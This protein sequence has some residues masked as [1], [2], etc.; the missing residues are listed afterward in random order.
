MLDLEIV[1]ERSLGCDAWEFVLGMHFSQAVSIIQ[2]QV[3]TIRGVQVLYSD[4]R[5]DTGIEIWIV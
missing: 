3:G 4:Q 5:T 2:S 1:P